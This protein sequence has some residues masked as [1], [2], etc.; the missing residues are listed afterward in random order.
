MKRYN[1][2]VIILI[3]ALSSTLVSCG[4]N[5]ENEGGTNTQERTVD[6]GDIVK[7]GDDGLIYNS[8][9]DGISV[10]QTN[11]GLMNVIATYSKKNYVPK[12]MYIN[13][14]YLITIGGIATN[15]T[16]GELTSYDY[17]NIDYSNV[18]VN[19]FDV[20]AIKALAFG[21]EKLSLN[22]YII[23]SFSLN[24]QYF[25]SRLYS[26]TKELY[27]IFK[28]TNYIN[29]IV[30]NEGNNTTYDYI[31]NNITYSEKGQSKNLSDIEEIKDLAT[32][33]YSLNATLIMKINL[34]DENII[35]TTKGYYGAEFQDLYMS[36]NAL[37]PIFEMYKYQKRSRCYGM[38]K[39][40]AYVL[41]VSR[42]DLQSTYQLKLENYTIYDRY[43]IKDYGDNIYVC[44]TNNK[45]GSTVISYDTNLSEIGRLEDIAHGEEV[46][47][48]TYQEID[49]KKYCYITT[50]RK[51]DPLFKI[52]ITT[53]SEIHLLSELSI[54]GYATYLKTLSDRYMIGI[55]YD[56]NDSNADTS[57][58]KVSFYDIIDN[59]INL[60]NYITISKVVEC[61]AISNEKAIAIDNDN[62][63]FGFSILRNF[64]GT[65]TQ[66]YYVFN[67]VDG[68]L[69]DL[70]YI[71]NFENGFEREQ[72]V[73]EAFRKYISRVFVYNGYAY[74]I[75]D[76]LI[77]SYSL[78]AEQTM[79][80]EIST[81]IE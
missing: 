8:Q 35:A 5:T 25:T 38:Y 2:L 50:F 4:N 80:S 63:V 75:A 49:D 76:S 57:T 34:T 41:K 24:G 29:C 1:I 13:G 68:E 28:Y 14:N 59:D 60:I 11:M 32:E 40:Y 70:A 39:P 73:Y 9:S 44:T 77:S 10:T 30:N 12:E 15:F 20:T 37:F 51:T 62:M 19:V 31:K 78:E 42:E 7:I 26:E 23:Y 22:D 6:E 3:I 53:P 58:I 36:E 16:A 69:N 71:T 74:F 17:Y 67:V 18:V 72:V 64:N 65:Y 21:Q 61:E 33:H 66:G 56:G 27:V 54:P 45:Y 52:D 47:S 55:G 46:K 79:I 81:I 43:A 48:V